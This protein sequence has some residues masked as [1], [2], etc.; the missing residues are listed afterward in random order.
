MWTLLVRAVTRL[1][2]A[3]GL[4]VLVVGVPVGQLRN[5][6][7]PLP[8]HMPTADELRRA[9]TSRDWLTDAAYLDALS[10]LLWLLWLLFTI[11]VVVEVTAAV[12]GVRAPRYR[13]L[14]PTQALA[15]ALVAGITASI[16]AAAPA[17][18]L[19]A[20]ASGPTSQAPPPAAVML[21]PAG[22]TA[23]ALPA[24]QAEARTFTPVGS[25][26]L[27]INGQEYTHTVAKGESLWRIADRY[28]GNPHRWPEI[29]ELNK[30][31]YWPHVSGRTTFHDPD[32]IF[33]GWV[34][35]LPADAA[36]PPA[37]PPHRPPDG[38]PAPPATTSPAP[39]ASPAATA[40]PPAAS[41]I[42]G[43]DGLFVP[44]AATAPAVSP[45]PPVASP[46]PS[47]GA[48]TTSPNGPTPAATPSA[49]TVDGQPAA[50]LPGWIQITGGFLGVGLAAGL[51]HAVRLVWQRRRHRYRPTPVLDD[52]DL[53]PP[54]AA[55][56]RIRQGLR[57]SAPELLDERPDRGPTVREYTAAAVKP[58]LPPIGPTGAEL[59]G[60]GTLPVTA[61][62]GLDGPA[63][64]DAARALLV[65]TLT[66]GNPHD[67]DAQGQAVIPAGTL[68]TL[69]GVSAVDLGPMQRLTVAATFADALTVIEEE[70]IRR[71]RLIADQEAADVTALR[72]EHALAEPL[73]Q[74]LLIAD[75]PEPAWHN[76][77][78]TAIRLGE[79]VE[80]GAALIGTWPPGTTLTVAADGATSGGDGR[81]VAVLD[82]ATATE[83][84]AML[85]EAHGDIT[86]VATVAPTGTPA[87]PPTTEPAVTD[88]V[89][90]GREATATEKPEPVAQPTAPSTIASTVP[91]AV[92]VLGEPA[93]LAQDGTKIRGLRAKS[94]ELLVYLAV[95][96]TG[97]SLSEIMEALW[98]DATLRRASERLST[99]VANLRGVIRTAAQPPTK[100]DRTDTT[101]NGK[102]GNKKPAGTRIE[103]V[104][105]TGGH[106]HLDP[107]LLRV[108]WWTVL[109]AYAHVATATDDTN[110]L[111]H[112]QTA[113]AAATGGLADGNDYEW[114]DT[115]REHVRRHLIKIHAQAADLLA[116][117]D[118]HQARSLCDTACDLDP[119]SD[120]LARR[121]MRAAA[122]VGDTAAI[123]QRLTH[124]RHALDDAGIDIDPAT[125]QLA[126]SLLRE[127]TQP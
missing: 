72:D 16:V 81:R 70:I 88:Q 108:D 114:I 122:A 28:L 54:L 43:D 42:P 90:P 87:S 12:R 23:A 18:S 57:R 4:L 97:A 51:L 89:T 33:P 77:L 102:A 35:T 100:P 83:M 8:Q 104:I 24:G 95:H 34:L 9:L 45:S 78:A 55:M 116:D 39:T 71:S 103:P 7:W 76:R 11:S 117:T 111:A 74:M 6:G 110:R 99:C 107:A 41:S 80:I 27:L 31:K 124:L 67:P 84:L 38:Q 13:L 126:A 37:R 40:S 48:V 62:L 17:P 3:A 86:T 56:T 112:L 30:G 82:T 69:L 58:P 91:V 63:A 94:L 52:P 22:T 5:I 49:S 65:A 26:T 119:L 1:V 113:I 53:T 127:P 105:N 14:A 61:G 106:Y 2:S 85:R 64:L 60:V 79:K 101:P 120:E 123:R 93:I 44:P 68:A 66:S 59:A 21:V 20:P 32:L 36:P 29:W 92:R 115:D 19:V 47:A 46:S 118:P 25:V 10:V 109:D 75:V 121:A 73:P 98:P 125:E 15:A 96:R 50:D